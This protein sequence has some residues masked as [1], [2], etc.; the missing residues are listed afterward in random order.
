MNASLCVAGVQAPLTAQIIGG[1]TVTDVT[2]AQTARLI[3]S[4]GT[5][6]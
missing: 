4:T 3:N 2:F 6:N 5:L 1:D